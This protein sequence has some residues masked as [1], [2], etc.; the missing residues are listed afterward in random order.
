MHQEPILWYPL[1][2]GKLCWQKSTCWWAWGE[3]VSTKCA[4]AALGPGRGSGQLTAW[5][6]GTWNVDLLLRY[7]TPTQWRHEQGWLCRR[8]VSCDRSMT[9]VKIE[10]FW[11]GYSRDVWGVKRLPRA[12]YKIELWGGETFLELVHAGSYDFS[13]VLKTI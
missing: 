6:T 13:H 5:L 11:K 7:W 4:E 12:Y 8:R 10:S 2:W 1:V 3:S 9:T